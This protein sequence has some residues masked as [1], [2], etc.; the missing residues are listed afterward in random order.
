[1][2]IGDKVKFLSEVGGGRVAGFQGKNIV[3]VEDEDGFQ[4]PTPISDVVVEESDDYSTAKVVV[5]K[6]DATGNAPKADTRKNAA[7]E[8]AASNPK[9]STITPEERKG[10]DQLSAFLAFV[11]I[12]GEDNGHAGTFNGAAPRFEEYLVNDSNYYLCLS[13]LTAD[14]NSWT[15]KWQGEIEPNTQ[16]FIE[17]VDTEDINGFG[18]VAFQVI[19]YKKGK[20]FLMK[21]T[22]NVEFRIDPLKFYKLHTFVD[23]PFFDEPAMLFT[24]VENDKPLSNFADMLPD[25]VSKAGTADNSKGSHGTKDSNKSSR[26]SLVHRYPDNQSKGNPKHSPYIRHRGLDDAMVVDLHASELLDSTD[27][28]KSGEILDYQMKVF[29]DTLAQY[30]DKKGQKLIFIHGKGEGI[31]RQAIINEL[32]YKYKQYPCQDASFQEYGYGATQ[33]TIK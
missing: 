26:D 2:K 4:I 11:K 6:A 32:R 17:E 12:A 33:V 10:G 29:R 1:M 27:G 19:A 5:H 7:I 21:D 22:V 13:Y 14:N 28:M 9:P 8:L 25:W 16:I 15:L 30:K 18:R 31:L 20:P 23:T 3:L 24:I